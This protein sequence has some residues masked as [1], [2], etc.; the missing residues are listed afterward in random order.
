MTDT[1]SGLT[2]ELKRASRPSCGPLGCYEES[3]HAAPPLGDFPPLFYC[4]KH[5]QT[6]NDL[7]FR[8]IAK[9]VR[10]QCWGEAV[11]YTLIIQ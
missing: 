2:L 11:P 10:Y 9:G 1:I 8:E 7:L 4:A 3:T 6:H 5:A